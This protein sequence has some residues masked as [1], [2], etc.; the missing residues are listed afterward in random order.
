MLKKTSD[1]NMHSFAL[2]I[3]FGLA[4]F[5]AVFSAL[6]FSPRAW[7]CLAALAQGKTEQEAL[8]NFKDAIK[9]YLAMAP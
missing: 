1:S 8:E 3:I 5:L 9:T 4:G 6:Y 2:I 7:G